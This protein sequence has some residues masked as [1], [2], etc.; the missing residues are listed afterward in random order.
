[1]DIDS[2][3][4][5]RL[6]GLYTRLIHNPWR[7][8]ILYLGSKSNY[9]FNYEKKCFISCS[10]NSDMAIQENFYQVILEDYSLPFERESFDVIIFEITEFTTEQ[11]K[12][13]FP[14]IYNLLKNNGKLIVSFKN[15]WSCEYLFSASKKKSFLDAKKLIESFNFCI[16]HKFFI[17]F[18]Q[19]FLSKSINK[20]LLKNE[21]IL[22]K[23]L[24]YFC[25]S[26]TLTAVKKTDLYQPLPAIMR[27][28]KKIEIDGANPSYAR[29]SL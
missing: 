7:H 28:S 14:Q 18:S 10:F 24:G 25:N 1:M 21:K 8:T 16:V 5:L 26:I 20:I 6:K 13:I 22:R 11:E 9:P 19:G 23:I 3:L 15:Y 29:D 12:E 2:H 27:I 4:S 17:S